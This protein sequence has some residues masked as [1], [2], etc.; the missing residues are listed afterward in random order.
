MSFCLDVSSPVL[1]SEPCLLR[2]SD[3]LFPCWTRPC[4]SRWATTQVESA[5]ARSHTHT[6]NTTVP[7]R[8]WS[9]TIWPQV[10]RSGAVSELA[11][12]QTVSR[13]IDKNSPLQV[14][15]VQRYYQQIVLTIV[16]K[17][18]KCK[19]NNSAAE[20]PL[21]VL[22]YYMYHLNITTAALTCRQHFN[23]VPGRGGA[24]FNYFINYAYLRKHI[25]WH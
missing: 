5:C 22:F 19:N 12:L 25:I 17:S 13:Q 20:S 16:L 1:R 7:H 11:P 24:S 2:V 3:R 6:L 23:I 14:L 4:V 21:S 9:D 18:I 15:E 10:V 8:I